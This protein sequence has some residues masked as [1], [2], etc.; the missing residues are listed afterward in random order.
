MAPMLLTLVLFAAWLVI[1]VAALAAVGADLRSLRLALTAP[2]LGTAVT[3]LPLFVLSYAG[4]GMAEVARPFAVVLL[5]I[6][7]GILVWRRPRLPVTA[8]P[9]VAVSV[10]GLLLAGWPMW[11]LG[12]G[13]LA[14]AN[15]DM[16]NYV[17]SG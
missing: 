15:D 5:V 11:G 12:F 16:A 9:V 1:G 2:A 13:W 4:V 6:A 8:A 10:A 7:G 3:V 14:E 17:L